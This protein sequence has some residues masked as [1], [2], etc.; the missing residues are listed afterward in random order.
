MNIRKSLAN[1]LKPSAQFR[2]DDDGGIAYYTPFFASILVLMGAY[3]DGLI[4]GFNSENLR[5]AVVSGIVGIP[6]SLMFALNYDPVTKSILQECV[7]NMYEEERQV[8]LSYLLS[9]DKSD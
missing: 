3:L 4:N 2:T 9:D 7:Y 1:R 5:Y 6:F 8:E